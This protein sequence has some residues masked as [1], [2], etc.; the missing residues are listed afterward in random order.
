[1]PRNTRFKRLGYQNCQQLP[2]DTTKM[3]EAANTAL[4]KMDTPTISQLLMAFNGEKAALLHALTENDTSPHAYRNMQNNINRYLKGTRTPSSAVKERFKK[5]FAVP[6]NR[7]LAIQIQG[8]GQISQDV[9][10]RKTEKPVV[11]PG[12]EVNDFLAIAIDDNDSGYEIFSSYYGVSIAWKS[13]VQI[14]MT[15]V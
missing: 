2:F 8:C 6:A 11:I 4:N 12:D 10:Y 15:W 1:M 14:K 7:S 9:G 13:N 3:K 5:L